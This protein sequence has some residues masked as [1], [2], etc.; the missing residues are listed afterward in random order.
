MLQ[1]EKVVFLNFMKS[2]TSVNNLHSKHSQDEGINAKHFSRGK[3]KEGGGVA[4]S[5]VQGIKLLP[6]DHC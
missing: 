2:M 5:G 6:H 4:D 1:R 3:N